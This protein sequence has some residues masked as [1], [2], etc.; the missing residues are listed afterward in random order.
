MLFQDKYHV[1]FFGIQATR[2]WIGK[3]YIKV[4]NPDD[5]E[6]QIKYV[7]KHI[8]TL[9]QL[10]RDISICYVVINSASRSLFAKW[11]NLIKKTLAGGKTGV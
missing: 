6:D 11:T 7:S 8:I 4:Y 3:K 1:T 2:A 5:K 9:C 10:L